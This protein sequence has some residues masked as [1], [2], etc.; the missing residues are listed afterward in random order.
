MARLRLSF[1]LTNVKCLMLPHFLFQVWGIQA[2]EKER[3]KVL[4][5]CVVV[6]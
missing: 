1:G 5:R 6:I 3:G 4:A 2:R